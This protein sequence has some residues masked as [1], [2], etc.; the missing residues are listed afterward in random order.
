MD[1]PS[2]YL[3]DSDIQLYLNFF[4]PVHLFFSRQKQADGN[5][6]PILVCFYPVTQLTVPN[7]MCHYANTKENIDEGIGK[8]EFQSQLSHGITAIV[9]SMNQTRS[10]TYL[11]RTKAAN[12]V[13]GPCTKHTS[14]FNSIIISILK[15]L[16]L[17]E[18]MALPK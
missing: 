15:K 9:Q 8:L 2:N 13:H 18:G 17:R 14:I 4:S 7:I 12:M 16:S 5:Q 10:I 6:V 1:L 11:I 3:L